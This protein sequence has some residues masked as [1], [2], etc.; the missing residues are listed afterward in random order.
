MDGDSFCGSRQADVMTLRLFW[1][2]NLY[3]EESVFEMRTSLMDV[4]RMI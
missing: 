2:G 4:D 3:E 1:E